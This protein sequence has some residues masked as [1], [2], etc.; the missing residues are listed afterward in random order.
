MSFRY[1]GAPMT[2]GDRFI[3]PL[4]FE[5]TS[6]RRDADTPAAAV[7]APAPPHA[8]ASAGAARDRHAM[9]RTLSSA[10]ALTFVLLPRRRTRSSIP[11]RGGRPAHP[12]VAYDPPRS[13]RS[14]AFTASR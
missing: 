3:N 8:G 10:L 12:T 13:S 4:G 2:N 11:S 7:A 6:Y 14:A 5:V 1:T 9:T